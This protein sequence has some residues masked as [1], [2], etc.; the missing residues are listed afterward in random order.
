MGFRSFD[1][2]GFEGSLAV[3]SLFFS[4]LNSSFNLTKD[5]DLVVIL[6]GLTAENYNNSVSFLENLRFLDKKIIYLL[7][8]QDLNFIDSESFNPN[9][10]E[11]NNWLSR[12]YISAT[13]TFKNNNRFIFTN[14]SID[15]SFSD[16]K[17]E[18]ANFLLAFQEKDLKWLDKYDGR[19]GYSVSTS[20]SLQNEIKYV[21]HGCCIGN[22]GKPIILHID[23]QGIEYYGKD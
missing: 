9:F 18:K 2:A 8:D 5:I 23:Q 1:L 13:I 19:F 22:F 20:F 14:G 16:W 21:Q 7:N 15:Q 12:Q 17:K 11:L 10:F 4:N 6:G 3:V